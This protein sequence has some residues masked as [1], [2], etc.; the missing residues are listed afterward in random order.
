MLNVL[1]LLPAPVLNYI[2]T[3][4]QGNENSGLKPPLPV[5]KEAALIPTLEFQTLALHPTVLEKKHSAHIQKN[6]IFLF[7]FWTIGYKSQRNKALKKKK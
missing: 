3:T 7:A 4:L 1:T 5:F 6:I 2:F